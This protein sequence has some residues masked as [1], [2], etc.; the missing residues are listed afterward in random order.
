M[1]NHRF[2]YHGTQVPIHLSPDPYLEPSL[3]KG[4]DEGDPTVPHVFVTP[5][6]LCACI[7][8]LKTATLSVMS[9]TPEFSF[10][11]YSRPPSSLGVGYVYKFDQMDY[12]PFEQTAARGQPTGKW[13]SFER[14]DTRTHPHLIVSGIEELMERYGVQVYYTN[15]SGTST[16][17]ANELTDAA[18]LGNRAQLVSLSQQIRSGRLVHLNAVSGTNPVRLL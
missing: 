12:L 16:D 8:S 4:L 9:V 5:D 3:S 11:I 13:V 14:L 17:I 6:E 2:F 15:M 7:F 10:A 1:S 18:Y